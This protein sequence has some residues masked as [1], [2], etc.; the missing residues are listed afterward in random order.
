MVLPTFLA[1]GMPDMFQNYDDA[2]S[3]SF[4]PPRLPDNLEAMDEDEKASAQEQFRRRHIH[5]FYLGFTQRMNEPHW[6]ALELS[7][8]LLKRRIFNSAGSPWEGLNTTLQMN[9]VRVSQ[10]WSKIASAKS[11]GTVP[12][13]PIVLSEQE[14]QQRV[15]LDKSLREVDS[16]MERINEVL[17]IASDGWTPHERFESSKE[18]AALIKEE[19][20]LAVSDDPWLQGMSERHWPFDDCDED[21]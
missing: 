16:E 20:L 4:V 9:I 7:T 1:S 15:A 18:R 17:G 5:F 14:A 11:D 8:G 10:N 19:G 6:H 3:I 2:E 13:C 21:E 12:A